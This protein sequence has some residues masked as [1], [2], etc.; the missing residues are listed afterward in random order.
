MYNFDNWKLTEV[1]NFKFLAVNI[2]VLCLVL[3]IGHPNLDKAF[4]LVPVGFFTLSLFL[5][6]FM[7]SRQPQNSKT[8]TFQVIY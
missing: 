3:V 4:I 7:I 8:I 6:A 2:V 1:E 5:L